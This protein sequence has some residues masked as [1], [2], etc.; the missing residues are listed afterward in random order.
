MVSINKYFIKQVVPV[1]EAHFFLFV[2]SQH[3]P[4]DVWQHLFAS[5]KEQQYNP[6]GWMMQHK[7][8]MLSPESIL[9]ERKISA[10]NF[11]SFLVLLLEI[12]N[13]INNRHSLNMTFSTY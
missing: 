8:L 4:T 7:S 10:N 5:L 13:L 2:Y 1:E 12:N 6:S 11:K 3:C 9:T